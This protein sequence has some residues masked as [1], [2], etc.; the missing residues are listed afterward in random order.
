[1][2]NKITYTSTLPEEVAA[3]VKDYA[4]RYRVSK[5]AVV[6][7]ALRQFFLQEKKR[8][9]REGFSK[10]AGEAEKLE[11]AEQGLQDFTEVVDR[12]ENRKTS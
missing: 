10:F 2:A 6:E 3:A 5:N 9:F 12:F 11:L 4:E 7:Q 8:E 1:M